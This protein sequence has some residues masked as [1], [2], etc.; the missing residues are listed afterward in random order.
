[1]LGNMGGE[2]AKTK[3]DSVPPSS[4]VGKTTTFN[5]TM[6]LPRKKRDAIEHPTSHPRYERV[7]GLG[8][9][10]MGEVALVRD[11]DIGRRV[12]VK[13]LLPGSNSEAAM[14]RFADEVRDLT[15]YEHVLAALRTAAERLR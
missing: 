7:R 10:G 9:G 11:L 3:K 6:V 1:M 13:R 2:Q 14:L 4:V 5:R 8:E 12:A 15:G